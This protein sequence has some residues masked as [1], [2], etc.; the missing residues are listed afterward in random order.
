MNLSK[1]RQLHVIII[2]CVLCIIA[3]TA[4]FFLSIKPKREAYEAAFA[5][6]ETASAL[7]NEQAESRARAD[8]AEAIAEKA[9]LQQ[10]LDVQMA[11]RMPNLDFSCRDRGMIT[12]WHEQIEKM[13]PMLEKFALNSSAKVVPTVF[14]LPSPPANP[15]DPAFDSDV[16][17][18]GPWKIQAVGDFTSL[19]N[20]IRRWNN[21][22][23]LMMVDKVSLWGTS[24]H[25]GVSYEVTCYVF[26]LAKGGEMIPMAGGGAGTQTAQR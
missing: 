7:A 13:G 4:L 17:T 18:F 10:A 19:M 2:G 12:L 5:R 3:G 22:Q 1:L 16:L 15:N 21:C 8:L 23:R 26:P 25:L 6:Y 9:R 20:D 24:S 14:Q 11:K